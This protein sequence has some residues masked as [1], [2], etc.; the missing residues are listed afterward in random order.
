MSLNTPQQIAELAIE[1]GA[2]KAHLPTRTLLTLGFLAGAFIAMGFLLDLHVSTM[3]PADW[4]SFGNLLGAAVFPLGL[5]L[6]VLG[7]GELLTGNMMTLPM[8]LFSRRA[9]LGA[10]L[11]N[12]GWVTLANLLG[13]LFIAYFFGHMLGL[14]EGPFLAKTLAIAKAK[15]S[16]DFLHAF[17]SGIGCNWLVCLA[18]WLSYASKDV[19]GKILG[20]WF[21]VMAF[22][23]IGFQH[24]V[25][26]MFILPAAIFAGALDWTTCL[27]NLVPVFLGNAV[28]GAVFVGLAYSVSYVAPSTALANPQRSEA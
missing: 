19:P 25:A 18:V 16:A 22:V 3:I 2:K 1:T 23:A 6:V 13:A 8:A 17:I 14:T 4:A 7:G 26:N 28:G 24:V 9:G 21:P 20:M 10:V 12:W 27:T 15:A 5:I 11:R